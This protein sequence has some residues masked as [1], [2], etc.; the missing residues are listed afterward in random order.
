MIMNEKQ[1]LNQLLK[2]FFKTDGSLEWS[3][4]AGVSIAE[5]G[6]DELNEYLLKLKESNDTDAPE[7]K[8]ERVDE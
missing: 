8:K 7:E 3:F 2:L 5:V 1:A 4:I 6:G